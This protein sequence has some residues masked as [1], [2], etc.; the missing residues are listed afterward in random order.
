MPQSKSFPAPPHKVSFP[1]PPRMVSLPV[2]PKIESSPAPPSNVSFP[3]PPVIVLSRALPEI[4]AAFVL[5]AA[6]IV[7]IAEPTV[8]GD[9]VKFVTV[10]FV[11]TPTI[12]EKDFPAGLIM[13]RFLPLAFLTVRVPA[14]V[15]RITSKPLK[16]VSVIFEPREIFSVT[17]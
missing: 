10:K 3:F 7:L 15:V 5:E 12:V 17:A 11:K 9:F 2:F 16:A 14:S 4:F 6:V 13:F 8:T 1:T